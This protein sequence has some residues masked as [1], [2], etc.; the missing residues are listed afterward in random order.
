[1]KLLLLQAFSN[2][3]LE[4]AKYKVMDR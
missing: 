1:M 3:V 4:V 2:N